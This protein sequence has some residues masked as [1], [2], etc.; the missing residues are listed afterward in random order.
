MAS[1]KYEV[2]EG[3]WTL[4]PVKS[5]LLRQIVLAMRPKQW[6]KNLL[7]FLPL[8]FA[9]GLGDLEKLLA[10]SAGFSA[11]CLVSS[12]IYLLNDVH[13]RARDRLHPLKRLRPVA[14]G[15]LGVSHAV[16]AGLALSLGAA[17]LAFALSREF[18]VLVLAYFVVNLLY[19]ESFKHQIIL[20]VL[21]LGILFTIRV[22]AGSVL[23]HV[24]ASYWLLICTFMLALFLGFAKRRHEL[25]LLEREGEGHRRVLA[26]YSA[27]FLDQM[28]AV[29]TTSTAMAYILYTVSERTFREFGTRSL[30]YTTPFVLYG[31]FRYL[32]LIHRKKEGGDPASVIFSDRALLAN[33][34]LWAAAVVAIVYFHADAHVR[35]FLS[36]LPR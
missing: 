33:L 4:A 17:V 26:H 15:R 24:E 34:F 2:I 27:Y 28:I 1:E 8:V 14:S 32:Y 30:V 11:F 9:K 16:A 35:N 3:A 5:G 18:G 10:V 13:D 6:V 36:V 29:V 31:I 19:T 23:A 12:G 7:L 20:D 21:T 25:T 22:I